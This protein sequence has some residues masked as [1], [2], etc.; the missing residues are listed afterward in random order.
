VNS[1]VVMVFRLLE[2]SS[3]Q[4]SGFYTSGDLFGLSSG[5]TYVDSAV[6]VTTASIAKL[7]LADLRQDIELQRMLYRA[8]CEQLDAAQQ[9][10]TTLTKKSAGQ[11][12]AAFLTMLARKQS[13]EGESFDLKLPMSRLDIADFLGMSI[14][15]V[16]RRITILK[17]RG[18]INVPNRRTI[19]VVSFAELQREAGALD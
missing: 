3:R 19:G 1:G 18:I 7:T 4:I 6:C 9:M 2:D 13:C 12:V 16:S 14:E 11:K 17:D 5:D 8:T 15:T 10:I